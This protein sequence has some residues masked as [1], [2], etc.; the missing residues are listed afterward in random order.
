MFIRFLDTSFIIEATLII[1]R[2]C[3]SQTVI[4]AAAVSVLKTVKKKINKTALCLAFLKYFA[5]DTVK[6]LK[7]FSA[8]NL[9]APL[10]FLC[11]WQFYPAPSAAWMIDRT[12]YLNTSIWKSTAG[13]TVRELD[14]RN[15]K[16]LRSKRRSHF[17]FFNAPGAYSAPP[18]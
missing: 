7:R 4:T 5:C 17:P 10:H 2:S 15:V 13:E 11:I 9:V 1:L 6:K 14:A 18:R 12:L 3:G 8:I 16:Y